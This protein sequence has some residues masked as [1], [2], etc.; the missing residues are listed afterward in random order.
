MKRLGIEIEFTGCKR[1]VVKE[2]L[3]NIWGSKARILTGSKTDNPYEYYKVKDK[4]SYEWT[5]L[6]D[7]SVRAEVQGSS[8]D[9]N[10]YCCELVSPILTA[11]SLKTLFEVTDIIKALGGITNETCGVHIHIDKPE[12]FN[13]L[14]SLLRK[15]I[16]EQNEIYDFFSVADW[17]REK[18]CKLYKNFPLLTTFRDEDA[19]MSFLFGK[20]LDKDEEKRNLRYFGL[21]LYS[22]Y[23]HNTVEFRIFNGTLDKVEIAKIIDWVLH[24]C[25]NINDISDYMPELGKVLYSIM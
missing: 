17:R 7:R 12:N 25:Y 23:T 24:F 11:S 4:D 6:R 15:W 20:Y 2:S 9:D 1:E 22:I 21:N 3:E 10:I 16:I 14:L 19:L 5:I 13:D 8:V 18:Y